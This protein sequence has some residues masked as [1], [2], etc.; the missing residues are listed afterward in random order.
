MTVANI[1]V[2]LAA[3]AAIGGLAWFGRAPLSWKTAC[4]GPW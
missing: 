1:S 2:L 3:A 4:S